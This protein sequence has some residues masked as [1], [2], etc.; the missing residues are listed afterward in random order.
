MCSPCPWV[1]FLPKQTSQKN[2]PSKEVWREASM[3]YCN[4][5]NTSGILWNSFSL[6]FLILHEPRGPP[7]TAHH[8][9]RQVFVALF[10]LVQDRHT[11]LH[12]VLVIFAF[13]LV[14]LDDTMNYRSKKESATYF[15]AW[16]ICPHLWLTEVNLNSLAWYHR[17]PT[18]QFQHS[19][20]AHLSSSSTCHPT[21]LVSSHSSHKGLYLFR[22]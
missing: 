11:F 12:D 15:Y 6:L 18:I 5:P 9:Y 20:L 14:I 7:N 2:F 1:L 21:L 10:P 19:L 3:S 16:H 8:L 22:R 4:V 13:P 17:A